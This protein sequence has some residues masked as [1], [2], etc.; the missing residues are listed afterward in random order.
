MPLFVHGATT[1]FIRAIDLSARPVKKISEHYHD[2]CRKHLHL[3]DYACF[4]S[5]QLTVCETPLSRVADMR[6]AWCEGRCWETRNSSTA[7]TDTEIT[8]WES[9]QSTY[10]HV[11]TYMKW[12]TIRFQLST[13]LSQHSQ[14]QHSVLVTMP[15]HPYLGTYEDIA[16]RPGIGYATSYRHCTGN[17]D[18]LN[19]GSEC[20]YRLVS[21]D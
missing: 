3:C 18:G 4:E 12:L 13:L 5:A 15:P 8:Q 1:S 11:H 17:R 14:R 21:P 6:T 16:Y 7:L 10:V 20:Q 19:V 2:C 9:N